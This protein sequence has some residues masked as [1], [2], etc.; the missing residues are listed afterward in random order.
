MQ[1]ETFSNSKARFIN[2]RSVHGSESLDNEELVLLLLVSLISTPADAVLWTAD[3]G[4]LSERPECYLAP[5]VTLSACSTAVSD[6]RTAPNASLAVKIAA[7]SSTTSFN[8]NWPGMAEIPG[9]P[10]V[11]S[12]PGVVKRKL[13]VVRN[14]PTESRLAIPETSG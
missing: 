10:R 7:P 14:I 2:R 12:H 5:A 13:K 8:R 3:H 1:C 9:K 6:L 11:G 4:T